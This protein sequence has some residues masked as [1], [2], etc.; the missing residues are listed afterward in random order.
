MTDTIVMRMKMTRT[1][2]EK[3]EE[4]ALTVAMKELTTTHTHTNLTCIGSDAGLELIRGG[5]LWCCANW[6]RVSHHDNDKNRDL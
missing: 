5:Q 6:H 1:R 3:E 4:A 2:E